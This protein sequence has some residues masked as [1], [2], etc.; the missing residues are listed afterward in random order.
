MPTTAL[1]LHA[2]AA[3]AAARLSSPQPLQ[4]ETGKKAL[5]RNPSYM[6]RRRR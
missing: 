4:Q 2:V 5:L 6:M 1:A 3:L